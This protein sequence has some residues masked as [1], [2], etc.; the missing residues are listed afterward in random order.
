M[1][2]NIS[3]A[4]WTGQVVLPAGHPGAA[5][6]CAEEEAR[7]VVRGLGGSEGPLGPAVSP[8]GPRGSVLALTTPLL[9]V[10]GG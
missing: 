4:R 6:P 9:R 1:V 5:L 2:A 3:V 7:A 8:P 10:I